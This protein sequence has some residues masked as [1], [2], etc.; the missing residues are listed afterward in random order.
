MRRVP[1]TASMTE[2]NRNLYIYI[3]KLFTALASRPRAKIKKR[4]LL[5]L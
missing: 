1:A 5:V 3:N 4:E 2:P